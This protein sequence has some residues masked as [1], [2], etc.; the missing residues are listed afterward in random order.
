[1]RAGKTGGRDRQAGVAGKNFPANYPKKPQIESTSISAGSGTAWI[2][3]Q[4]PGQIRFQPARRLIEIDGW[5]EAVTQAT[6][7]EPGEY[8]VRLR[9]DNFWADDS[10]FDNQCCWSNAYFPVTVTP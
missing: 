6:F 8:V 4:G 2:W 9:I 1:M 7:T 3:H 5:D 10:K